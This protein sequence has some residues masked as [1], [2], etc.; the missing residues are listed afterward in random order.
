MAG[1]DS[2]TQLGTWVSYGG[3]QAIVL[4]VVLLAVAGGLGYL[5]IRLRSPLE[6][7]RPGR[8]LASLLIVIWLLSIVTFLVCLG[9]YD[10]QW[11]HVY[12]E[13]VGSTAPTDPITPVTDTA[14]ALTF[15]VAFMLGRPRGARVAFVSAIIG[16][17]AAPLIFELPFDLVVMG[18]TYPPIPPDP[19][20]Y[21]LLFFLP[22]LLIEV[23]TFALLTLSPLVRMSRHTLLALAAMFVVFALWAVLF[24]FSYPASAGPIVLND[25]SKLLAFVAAIT[26]F[27]PA[28]W[29]FS[30]A[31]FAEARRKPWVRPT[32]PDW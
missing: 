12:P 18:R 11:V 29:R 27:V 23:S 6:A 4:A 10:E 21:R 20:L 5:A 30:R 15:V 28:G 9:A 26:L 32:G 7:R 31:A 8:G 14:V 22:L 25:V 24:G 19:T 13:T 17:L 1:Q 2:G 3:S 16:A